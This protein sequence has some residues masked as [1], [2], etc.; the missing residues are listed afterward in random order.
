VCPSIVALPSSTVH[1]SCGALVIA[2]MTDAGVKPI[3]VYGP[4]YSTQTK[5]GDRILEV[6]SSYV[7]QQSP[8]FMASIF[9]GNVLTYSM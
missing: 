5:S 6:L 7:S 3:L 8:K 4:T 1:F 2:T 9:L